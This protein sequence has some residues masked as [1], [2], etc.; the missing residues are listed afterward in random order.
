MQPAER[1]SLEQYLAI[2]LGDTK[3]EYVD[4]TVHAMAGGT[5]EHAAIAANIIGHLRTALRDRPCQIYTSD[6]RIAVE[7]TDLRT[8]P[9]VT[10]V[11]GEVQRAD[12]GHSIVNPLVLFEVTSDSSA[13]WDRGGKFA[14]YRRI[15]ALR[16][17]VV[18]H[19]LERAVEHHVRGPG[20]VW[21]LRDLGP[22]GAVTLTSLDVSLPLD[23]IYLK[24]DV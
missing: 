16:E 19:H 22:T 13:D 7:A 24:L 18:V 12:R 2:D 10:V 21:T 11:C 3:H 17:Y 6:A 8:Y 9:D 23:E 14:H 4:G 5:P 20:D 15:P 1:L